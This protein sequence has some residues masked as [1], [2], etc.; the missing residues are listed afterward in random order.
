MLGGPKAA[1][2]WFADLIGYLS[3]R[4]LEFDYVKSMLKK[5]ES[6]ENRSSCEQHLVEHK[7]V[8]SEI[9]RL[10]PG[11]D[12]T[13]NLALSLQETLSELKS[14]FADP[15]R[16]FANREDTATSVFSPESLEEFVASFKLFLADLP[17]RPK[18]L[19]VFDKA[20]VLNHTRLVRNSSSLWSLIAPAIYPS[21][22]RYFIALGIRKR[23]SADL[24]A[25]TARTIQNACNLLNEKIEEKR[26]RTVAD[27]TRF[28]GAVYDPIV[29][30][31][32]LGDAAK[33]PYRFD[34]E[35][36]K[37]GGAKYFR[38]KDGKD[39]VFSYLMQIGN[40]LRMERTSRSSVANEL[41]DSRQP[42]GVSFLGYKTYS[43]HIDTEFILAKLFGFPL[44]NTG[45]DELFGGGGIFLYDSPDTN[46]RKR[47]A[48]TLPGRI[49]L[50]RGGFGTGKTSFGLTNA[51]SVAQAG[52]FAIYV[53]LEFDQQQTLFNLERLG[54]P[55]KGGSFKTFCSLPQ[56]MR[57]FKNRIRNSLDSDAQMGALL[58]LEID[59]DSD[60]LQLD[61]LFSLIN[62]VASSRLPVFPR[63]VVVDSLNAVRREFVDTLVT[64]QSNDEKMDPLGDNASV[65][66]YKK[67]R[68]GGK[69][70]P[71]F[72]RFVLQNLRESTG[73]GLN[74]ML[75]SEEDDLSWVSFGEDISDT[76]I[77]LYGPAEDR[78][79]P[80][81][82]VPGIFNRSITISKSR[83]QKEHPGFHTFEILP[84]SGIRIRLATSAR[85][86]IIRS[87]GDVHL[88]PRR[89]GVPA[90]D[91]L[92]EN[93]PE[94][95]SPRM[96]NCGRVICMEGALGT[97]KTQFGICFLLASSLEDHSVLA[98]QRK[99]VTGL[100][101]SM[102]YDDLDIKAKSNDQLCQAVSKMQSDQ[103]GT[104]NQIDTCHLPAGNVIPDQIIMAVKGRLDAAIA[105]GRPV[106]RVLLDNPGE[107]EDLCPVLA[108]DK[109]WAGTLIEFLRT[110]GVR[111]LVTNRQIAAKDSRLIRAILE[112]VDTSI[113]LGRKEI[114]GESVNTIQINRSPSMMHDG[115]VHRILFSGPKNRLHFEPLD[116][117][118]YDNEGR[119]LPTKVRV[120]R[121]RQTQRSEEYW[122]HL[123]SVIRTAFSSKIRFE[124]SGSFGS[125][126]DF[127]LTTDSVFDSLN[128]VEIDEFELRDARRSLARINVEDFVRNR[129]D[130]RFSRKLDGVDTELC[131]QVVPFFD[132]TACLLFD[133]E[134]LSEIV[135]DSTEVEILRVGRDWPMEL[136]WDQLGCLSAGFKDPSRPFFSFPHTEP[137]NWNCLF[138]EIL[139]SYSKSVPTNGLTLWEYLNSQRNK[140]DNW[141]LAAS[142]VMYKLISP[143]YLSI[144][145]S[146]QRP[147]SFDVS[148]E[149]AVVSRHWFTT[150]HQTLDEFENK[151]KSRK[152][153][154]TQFFIRRLPGNY[155]VSGEWYLG[156]LA[157]SIATSMGSKILKHVAS[158][159]ADSDRFRL[160][161]GLPVTTPEKFEGYP[162]S[163]HCG[164]A[165]CTDS[166][167]FRKGE[168]NYID[169]SSI[170][171]YR[172]H[173]L[174]LTKLLKAI[175]RPGK[176]PK[177]TI[178][179]SILN[180][181]SEFMDSI[182][183]CN[184]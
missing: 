175:V 13:G 36:S 16:V 127:G 128:I 3:W 8:L 125:R 52:G 153:K 45:I 22:A 164:L 96:V 42:E 35:G 124:T 21:Q 131:N 136:S 158:Q 116:S 24:D 90:I 148:A 133:F 183:S 54:F 17:N 31:R 174:S 44:P 15:I 154:S 47:D 167:F 82:H 27:G 81:R 92:L 171:D 145:S 161:V 51:A 28:P 157:G 162:D 68:I 165:E 14:D 1:L 104:Y 123:K 155:T 85:A 121:R 94:S 166:D 100:V 57:H 37:R 160:G 105:E 118:S 30:F 93:N 101:I 177:E 74:I 146:R 20:G 43:F 19:R 76:V 103:S 113:V 108:L 65:K 72:R 88:A 78:T 114:V 120:F 66:N 172:K 46:L 130:P 7:E 34:T 97:F 169:R 69:N 29:L 135:L 180:L 5:L 140:T 26:R 179:N 41:S 23:C 151:R 115:R 12:L 134:K 132:N 87:R 10:L 159:D 39:V 32:C 149:G 89:F 6:T 122:D 152:K 184:V 143:V 111:I 75:L 9:N 147:N 83:Y 50:V 64:N 150:L 79:L 178:S 126:F 163:T 55:T 59:P 11:F 62:Q 99:P 107:W 144:R 138:F 60:A 129:Y 48:L 182:K 58:V 170:V 61:M 77:R 70:D 95:Q 86:A 71:D 119:V 33:N 109:L 106:T 91:M 102:R 141:L 173:S 56:C 67:R 63:L 112:Q 156:V 18:D 2:M 49:I 137:E 80:E 73:Y 176:N 4:Q 84:G 142:L 98:T 117:L 53:A 40:F 110:Y 25:E 168:F 139:A 181:W 38:E